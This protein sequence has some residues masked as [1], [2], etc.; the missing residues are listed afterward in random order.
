L[1]ASSGTKLS[2][3]EERDSEGC[4]PLHC[5]C[6]HGQ[7]TAGAAA[8][9]CVAA[10]LLSKGADVHAATS[11]GYT[12]LYYAAAGGTV[13]MLDA[14][15]EG[16]ADINAKFAGGWT[17]LHHCARRAL[18]R[19]G[20]TGALALLLSLLE[21]GADANA[22]TEV[23]GSAATALKDEPCLWE[24]ATGKSPLYLALSHGTPAMVAALAA[25]GADVTRLNAQ[26]WSATHY[27]ARFGSRWLGD[28]VRGCYALGST[29][30]A[31]FSAFLPLQGAESLI[32]TLIMVGA[33]VKD[34]VSFDVGRLS[35]AKKI[36]ASLV[37]QPTGK[38]AK[39]EDYK[40][41]EMAIKSGTRTMARLLHKG[42]AIDANLLNRLMLLAGP[43]AVAAL[44]PERKRVL[45]AAALREVASPDTILSACLK[46]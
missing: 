43:Q 29:C 4:T 26:G 42:D 39:M 30:C 27:A 21:H 45:F 19:Q 46:G 2:I 44:S 28:S 20:A 8:A 35:P 38:V 1:D 5:V 17:V 16:G 24:E 3:L 18:E 32:A 23:P 31:T 22:Q 14:L 33:P 37:K 15:V 6:L 13:A 25:A 41:E 34:S 36:H 9:T 10:A 11:R 7:A 12:P 40:P